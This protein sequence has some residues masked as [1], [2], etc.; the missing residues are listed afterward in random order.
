MRNPEMRSQ[1]DFR[2]RI[3]HYS[4]CSHT[5]PM[6]HPFLPLELV[7]NPNWWFQ[8]AGISFDESFYLDPDAHPQRRAM[9]RVLWQR[10]GDLGLGEADPSR[11]R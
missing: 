11:G 2:L 1:A 5:H 8:T 9:R 3:T 7:F 4:L 10:Y 6:N